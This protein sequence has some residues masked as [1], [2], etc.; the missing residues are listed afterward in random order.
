[1]SLLIINFIERSTN[2]IVNF[3]NQKGLNVILQ[4]PEDDEPMDIKILGVVCTG[5]EQLITKKHQ[6][7]PDYIFDLNVP[8]FC[9]CFS[10]QLIVEKFGGTFSKQKMYKET[11][12]DDDTL[13]W[14]NYNIGITSIPD[15]FSIINTFKTNNYIASFESN[16]GM[17][18]CV[19]FHP[20]RRKNIDNLYNESYL[21]EFYSKII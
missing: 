2:N 8:I 18:K 3:F 19:M 7:L 5:S 17:I 4:T 10:A 1:M 14:T 6:L 20:E 12:L 21:E 11:Y 13:V 16:D 15:N 9:I